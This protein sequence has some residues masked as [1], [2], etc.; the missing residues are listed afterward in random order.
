MITDILKNAIEIEGLARI[1]RDGEPLP[2]TFVLLREKTA[3]LGRLVA[4]LETEPR[5][6][7]ETL[8]LSVTPEE[9]P[10]Q[11]VASFET[12][13]QS[14]TDVV[15]SADPDI[16]VDIPAD[17]KIS[18]DIHA[19]VQAE[20]DMDIRHHPVEASAEEGSAADEDDILLSLTVEDEVEEAAEK[21]VAFPKPRTSRHSL[22]SI[23]T[24]NDRFLFAR[25]LF[26]G[27]MKMFDATIGHLESIQE[28]AVV[29]EY[30]I[31]ELDWDPETPAVAQFLDILRPHFS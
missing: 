30:F 8:A 24:L 10:A 3:A 2:E 6:A 20:E 9:A 25:E 31:D 18:V 12:R 4:E 22:K 19:E 29:E 28:M 5:A 16:P 23:F 7:A 15:V 21:V 11:P 13:T 17:T 27:N 1:I 14:E 26:N